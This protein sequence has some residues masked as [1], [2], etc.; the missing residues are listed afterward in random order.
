MVRICFAGGG[1]WANSAGV[2]PPDQAIEEARRAG[3]DLSLVDSNL[4]LSYEQR[5]LKH[6]Q[7]LQKAKAYEESTGIKLVESDLIRCTTSGIQLLFKVNDGY[8]VK[9]ID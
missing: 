6:D 8:D 3:I 7:A 5:W 2:N 4:A 9:L 1:I